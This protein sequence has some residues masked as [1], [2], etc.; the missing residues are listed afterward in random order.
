MFAQ[1]GICLASLF[2]TFVLELVAF[3][4][5]TSYLAKQGIALDSGHTAAGYN[6]VDGTHGAHGPHGDIGVIES[7]HDHSIQ[8]PPNDKIVTVAKEKALVSESS[9]TLEEGYGDMSE[10]KPA[11]A[12]ILGVAI[13]EFGV[14]F[15]SVS[16]PKALGAFL[17]VLHLI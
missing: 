11:A 7:D 13:L 1:F 15:H 5:G 12:Q 16:K 10:E 3:R 6:G 8:T 2:F 17:G 14:V 9:S 4:L